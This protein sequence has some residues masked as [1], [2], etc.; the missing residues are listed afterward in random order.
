MKQLLISDLH[1]DSE[2][3]QLTQAFF[4]FLA[5]H[6]SNADE[7]YILGD[8]FEVW[9][10]DDNISALSEIL[11]AALSALS[12]KKYLMHGNRDFLLGDAFCAAAGAELLADPF[13]LELPTGNALLMHGDSLCTRDEMYMRARAALRSPAFQADFLTKSIEERTVIANQIRG[14]SKALTR[15]TAADIM[16]VT[17]EEVV[18]EMEAHQV[19]L[20]IHGHTHRPDIHTVALSSGE[21]QRI[22][23]GDW[24]TST[25]YLEI[26]D[27]VH[28][29]KTFTF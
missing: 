28:E 1:L 12:A 15:E 29:L 13:L 5:E 21:G 14:E 25:Q 27:G 22:V 7:L 4:R 3:P 26:I 20:L 18:R 10:G 23:L 9:L 2:Q 6:A 17:P 19:R 24:Q 16:D 11:V 8:F